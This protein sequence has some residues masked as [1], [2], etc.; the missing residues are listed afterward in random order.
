MD[1][2]MSAAKLVQPAPHPKPAMPARPSRVYLDVTN[3]CQ[4]ACRHCC[5]SSGHPDPD[6]L[7]GA[8][9]IDVVD[10]V[11]RMGV[12]NLVLSGGEPLL[13]QELPELLGHAVRSG[14]RVTLLTNGLLIDERCARHLAES[15]VRVKIS[16]DGATAPTHDDLRGPG[17]FDGALASLARLVAAGAHELTVHYTVHRKNLAE[18]D[19]VPGL[20]RDLGVRNLVIGTIKP[21]GRALANEELL[22]DPCMAPYVQQ[23]VAALKRAEG[24][25]IQHLADRGWEGFGCPAVCNKLG[26]TATGR[27]TTCAFFGPEMLGES[28]RDFPLEELW[29]RHVA[30]GDRFVANDACRACSELARC[31]GGCRARAKYYHGDINAP[32]PYCCAFHARKLLIDRNRQLFTAAL[33]DPFAA[34]CGLPTPSA[35]GARP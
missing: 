22:I 3:R 1:A 24:I 34:F 20:L 19:A 8:E 31:G 11:R 2:V 13:R 9:L 16:L 12:P 30:R 4:L 27:L 5:T 26:I 17:A 29:R 25:E 15:G 21:S 35:A 7:T 33:R 18:L 6:E 14:L 10:Q 23:R 32:D 28:I